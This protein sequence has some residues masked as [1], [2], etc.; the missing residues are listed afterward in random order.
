MADCLPKVELNGQI[1]KNP[2]CKCRI[3]ILSKENSTNI[4]KNSYSEVICKIYLCFLR[5]NL[6]KSLIKTSL[7]QCMAQRQP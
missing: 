1:V 3:S 5:L 7:R 6:D 4:S 2:Y